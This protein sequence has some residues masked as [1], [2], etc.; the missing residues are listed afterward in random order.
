[1]ASASANLM[2][3]EA[4][5]DQRDIKYQEVD[6][7]GLPAVRI[8]YSLT[9]IDHLDVVFWFDKSGDTVHLG[10]SVIARVPKDRLEVGLRSVNS[11]N[12]H[13]RWMTFYLDDD[14]DIV[15]SYDAMLPPNMVGDTCHELLQHA[16]SVCDEAYTKIMR[17]LWAS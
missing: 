2:A 9:N 12:A 7:N 15:A 5:L 10:T 11:V 6:G 3:F 8:G 13:F 1:M 17:D 16:I 4:A 14:N